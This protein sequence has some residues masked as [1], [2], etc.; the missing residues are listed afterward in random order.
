MPSVAA[1]RTAAFAAPT[2]PTANAHALR[3]TP[4]RLSPPSS[5]APP[6][7][8]PAARATEV[9]PA[10]SVPT[11]DAPPISPPGVADAAGLLLDYLNPALTIFQVLARHA[12]KFDQLD[13]W[14]QQPETQRKIERFRAAESRRAEHILAAAQPAAIRALV[15]ALDATSKETSR[16]AATTLLRISARATDPS[17]GRCS[18]GVTPTRAAAPRAAESPSNSN[19][20]RRPAEAP[21]PEHA[22]TQSQ[23]PNPKSQIPAPAS[24][25]NTRSHETRRGP[26]RVAGADRLSVG[27]GRGGPQPPGV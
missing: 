27:D 8:L 26:G 6:Q 4:T 23:I 13:A 20:L 3:L 15:R 5:A 11:T 14:I 17:A 24:D 12:V 7:P 10:P 22:T 1:L 25:R 21:A 18:T 16:R 2:P 9:G 19:Q